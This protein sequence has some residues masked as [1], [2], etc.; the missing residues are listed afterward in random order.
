MKTTLITGASSGIGKATAFEY[1][2]NKYNLILVARRKELLSEIKTQIE[3][4]YSVSVAVIV[5]DLA[6]LSSADELFSEVKD[7]NLKV[8]V[9]INNAGFGIYSEL[10]SHDL[11]QLE[12]MLVLNIITLSKLTRL[13]ASKMVKNGGG[14]IINIASTAAFQPVPKL[15]AYAATKSYVMNFSDAIAYE[16]KD[17]NVHV[18]TISPGA[19]ESE[20]GKAAGFD[21]SADFYK[22]N[23]TSKDLAGFIYKEMIAKKTNSIHGFKNAFMAFSNRFAPRKM[24]VAIAANIME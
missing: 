7:R 21:E 23:P 15:A 24:T 2:K 11:Q 10:L 6:K 13:F 8:D 3:T 17:K 16:F 22:N 1:A 12:N 20:F 19:T 9:L 5:M 4:Q 18:L 14:D